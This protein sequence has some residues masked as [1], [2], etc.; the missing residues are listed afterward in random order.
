MLLIYDLLVNGLQIAHN[1]EIASNTGL[2]T[3]IAE[4]TGGFEIRTGIGGPGI[5]QFKVRVMITKP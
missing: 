2:G 5:G 4:F 3:V 1:A